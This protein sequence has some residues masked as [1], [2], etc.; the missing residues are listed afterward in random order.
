MK[1]LF[2]LNAASFLL[3]GALAASGC[4]A[5]FDNQA[6][7]EDLRILAVKVEPPE[8]RYDPTF[9]LVP[10]NQ[11]PPQLPMPSYTFD[12]TVYAFD[13]RGGQGL[14]EIQVCP[15]A[16]QEADCSGDKMLNEAIVRA[17]TDAAA[18][19]SSDHEAVLKEAFDPQTGSGDFVDSDENPSGPLSDMRFSFTF[20]PEAIDGILGASPTGG[21]TA[22]TTLHLASLSM[23]LKRDPE[24]DRI[25]KARAFKRSPLLVDLASPLLP[26]EFLTPL[27]APFGLEPCAGPI[28][29]FVDGPGDCFWDQGPNENPVLVGFDF[30]DPEEEAQRIEEGEEIPPIKISWRSDVGPNPVIKARPGATVHIRPVFAPGTFQPYQVV[31]DPI[32]GSFS[33]ENR[34]E[35]MVCNWYRTAGSV[36]FQTTSTESSFQPGGGG[37]GGGGDGPGGDGDGEGPGDGPPGFL[38]NNDFITPVDVDWGLPPDNLPPGAE[39][40]E[41]PNLVVIGERDALVVVIKDQRGGTA[42]GQIT[43]EYAE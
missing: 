23:E 7:I 17:Q 21:I 18:P 2:H 43:V 6:D 29:P 1:R 30:F 9:V 13:P 40:V 20:G 41:N 24:E 12:A 4:P 31:V 32:E 19:L 10:P 8:L 38:T 42:V 26:P 35:D 37:P 5:D 27:L 36:S 34:Y 39:N 33:I 11:R 22:A 28:D 3:A 16:P 25:N 14:M 15:F